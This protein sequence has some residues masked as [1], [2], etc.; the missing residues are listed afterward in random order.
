MKSELIGKADKILIDAPCSGLGV[1]SKKPDIK[2][3]RNLGDIRKIVNIQYELLKKGAS[4]LKIGGIIVYSTCT[5]EPEEND[6]IVNKFLSKNPNFSIMEVDKIVPK[7]IINENGFVP[8]IE[9]SRVAE[10]LLK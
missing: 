8:F 1:L 7:E 2:W 6:E 3:K 5:I 10:P 9:V 4:L